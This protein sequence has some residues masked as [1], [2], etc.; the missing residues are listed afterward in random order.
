MLMGL[1][2][3]E[4]AKQILYLIPSNKL[5]NLINFCSKLL[6][7]LEKK[8]KDKK[9]HLDFLITSL[10][11]QLSFNEDETFK[12]MCDKEKDYFYDAYIR[13]NKIMKKEFVLLNSSKH[14]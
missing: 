12:N 8:E 13:L 4:D 7:Y 11:G 9:R 14:D 3:I 1:E 6:D 5:P 2:I 10:A